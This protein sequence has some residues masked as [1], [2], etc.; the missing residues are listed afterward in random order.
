MAETVIKKQKQTLRCKMRATLKGVTAEQ[1]STQSAAI[2]YA[3]KS[4]VGTSSHP[5]TIASFVALPSEP[6]L[7]ELH[8]NLPNMRLVYPRSQAGGTM[9]FHHVHDL[10]K[11]E[12]GIYNIPQPPDNPD[13]L[14]AAT[15]IDFFLC[16]GFAF[17]EFGQRLG[18]GGGYY[19]RLLSQRL[20]TSRLIGICFKE[21][22]VTELP[23]EEHDIMVDQVISA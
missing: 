15:D 3:I 20:P 11:M 5:L 9:H 10:N 2:C 14:V 8:T 16:P 7:S 22:I 19:D 23:T 12:L 6:D 1:R 18:K 21:Q 17:T 13:T 4:M